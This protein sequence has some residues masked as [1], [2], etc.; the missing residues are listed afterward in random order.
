MVS[1]GQGV[2]DG[3][4]QRPR[5]TAGPANDVQAPQLVAAHKFSGFVAQIQAPAA[6]WT[7]HRPRPGLDRG[8]NLNPQG[9]LRAGAKILPGTLLLGRN[10]LVQVALPLAA[11][12]PSAFR[13]RH[14]TVLAAIL[15]AREP[16]E[17]THPSSPAPDQTARIF[18]G[19]GN[20]TGTLHIL[21][22]DLQTAALHEVGRLNTGSSTSFM[23]RSPEGKFLYTTQNRAD[24][25]S[26]FT[27]DEQENAATLRNAVEVRGAEGALSA[28]PAF[29][30]TD[31][32]GHFL[33]SA[34][35]RGHNVLV[36]ALLPTGDIGEQVQS[37]SAGR[38]AHSIRLDPSNRFAFAPFL[39]ADLVA[40]LR[41]DEQTGRLSENGEPLRT[42]AGAGPRHLDFHPNGHVVYVL[43]ELSSELIVCAFDPNSG[44]LTQ[45]E[46]HSTLP[47]GYGADRKRW[48]ADVHVHP[49]G[50]LL[51]ASNRD[52]DSLAIFALDP[53]S[54][55][56]RLLRHEDS[57]GKTPR[58]FA[59]TPDGR[60]LIAANQDSDNLAVFGVD[61]DAGGLN[62]VGTYATG[63]SPY[64]VVAESATFG[65]ASRT[66][67]T[68]AAALSAAK[69]RKPAP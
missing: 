37:W 52:H 10:S 45:K 55:S 69:T 60:F 33:L 29:V 56:A 20:A 21:S 40:Q 48:S 25:L 22:M 38:H 49:S 46:L 50:R 63:P 42:N 65:R 32:T 39:G 7:R 23:A 53:L 1:A 5:P 57:R 47:D 24:H 18:V 30:T 35:Y 27:F 62:F 14:R 2:A 6:D 28:G 15:S 54:G 19:C 31:A 68:T 36:H 67:A 51:F 66:T 3:K 43:T 26:A 9:A 44:R 13:G 34:N 64:F 58:I 4:P 11:F 59:I 16:M 61:V 17:N 8:G 41:F 12:G